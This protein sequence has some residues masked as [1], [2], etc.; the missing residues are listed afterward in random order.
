MASEVNAVSIPSDNTIAANDSIVGTICT[1]KN[2]PVYTSYDSAIC[3]ASLAINYYQLGY[4][5]A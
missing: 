2:V 1:K 4:H 5:R 3:Y